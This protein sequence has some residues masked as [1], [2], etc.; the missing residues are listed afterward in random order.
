MTS[1]SPDPRGDRIIK[2][3]NSTLTQVNLCISFCPLP[4]QD[5]IWTLETKIRNFPF[6]LCN[7]IPSTH[8]TA[9]AKNSTLLPHKVL[10][11]INFSLVLLHKR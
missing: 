7:I 6:F 11:L 9:K 5:V 10:S 1:F 8:T 4:T 2:T 3:K